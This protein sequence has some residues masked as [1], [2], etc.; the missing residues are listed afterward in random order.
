[1]SNQPPR[2]EYNREYYQTLFK[3]T[4]APIVCAC[5]C[6]EVFTPTTRQTMYK[7]RTHKCRVHNRARRLKLI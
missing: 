2:R 6:G 7:N 4:L 3:V 5:G 1:M